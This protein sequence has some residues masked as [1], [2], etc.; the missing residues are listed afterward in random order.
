MK[1]RVKESSDNKENLYSFIK[2]VTECF[3]EEVT[4]C[5]IYCSKCDNTFS[6]IN[7]DPFDFEEE[8]Y[9]LGWRATENDCYCPDCVKKYLKSSY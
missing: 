7:Y 3:I 8:I 6:C 5:N 2:E 9:E 4:E 1:K